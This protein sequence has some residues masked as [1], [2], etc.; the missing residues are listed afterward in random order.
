MRS[1]CSNTTYCNDFVYAPFVMKLCRGFSTSVLLILYMNDD[2]TG[3]ESFKTRESASIMSGVMIMLRK[4]QKLTLTPNT[5]A[6]KVS[7]TWTRSCYA[8]LGLP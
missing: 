6:R 7:N 2:V 3:G 5:A 8:T 1:H 4:F